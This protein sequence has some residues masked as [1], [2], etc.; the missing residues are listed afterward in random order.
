LIQTIISY[1]LQFCLQN[2][3]LLFESQIFLKRLRAT[4]YSKESALGCY[5]AQLLAGLV[6][7]S[8]ASQSTAQTVFPFQAKRIVSHFH[9]NNIN[10]SGYLIF[11]PVSYLHHGTISFPDLLGGDNGLRPKFSL[12]NPEPVLPFFPD[13]QGLT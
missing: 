12:Y 4:K 11:K 6:Q 8:F 5:V 10:L 13:R 7:A 1:N 2:I 9:S 3:L